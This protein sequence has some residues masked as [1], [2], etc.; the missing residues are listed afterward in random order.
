MIGLSTRVYDPNGALLVPARM[1]NAYQAARR[2]TITATLDM[3]NSVYDA[4]YTVGDGAYTAL[5]RRPS[6][7]LLQQLTYLVAYYPDLIAC[8]EIGVYTAR[9]QFQQ[10]L[11]TLTLNLR[12]LARLDS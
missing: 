8:T 1:E 3:R 6:V 4:G 9:I 7:R 11:D 5:V 12:L 2:G 10:R